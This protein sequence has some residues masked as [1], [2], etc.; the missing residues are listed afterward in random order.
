LLRW[1]DLRT[2][3]KTSRYARL[4]ENKKLKNKFE[5]IVSQINNFQA[6]RAG[7]TQ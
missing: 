3:L 1:K 6:T 4:N 7:I 2:F 5:P